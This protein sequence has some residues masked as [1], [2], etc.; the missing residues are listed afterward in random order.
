M[1]FKSFFLLA[2]TI[3]CYS[4]SYKQQ[5]ALF[6]QNGQKNADTTSQVTHTA[7]RIQPED[8]LQIRNLQGIKYLDG[9][10]SNAAGGSSSAGESFQVE[11]DG[12]VTLPVLGHIPITGLTRYEAAK[13][14]EQLYRDSLLNNPIIELKILNLKVTIFGEAKST[15]IFQLKKENTTLIDILGEAGGL[16]ASADEKHI[17]IIRNDKPSPEVIWVDLSNINVLTDPKIRL[18][19]NDII[20]IAQN[21]RAIRDDKIQNLSSLVQPSLLI[22]NTAL[23]IYTL[24]R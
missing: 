6:R 15:G 19:N 5:H 14:I 3:L 23:I 2:L 18:Q 4:C 20:Y 17:K 22:F 16:S 8:I 24:F 1:R 9:S 12:K 21:K 7:Y 13:K 10:S 11:E